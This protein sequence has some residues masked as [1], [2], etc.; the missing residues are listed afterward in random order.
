MM[1]TFILL[2]LISCSKNK[3]YLEMIPSDT[4]F[5]V[6]INP[7]SIAEKADFNT[8]EQYQLANSLIE[9]LNSSDPDLKNLVSEIKESPSSAGIDLLSPIYIFGKKINGKIITSLIMNMNNKT[10]FEDHLKTIYKAIYK[11]NIS[12]IDENG[13]T[14][15]EGSRKPFIAW[16]KKQFIFIAG[17]FGTKSTTLNTY[18][19]SLIKAENPLIKNLNFAEFVKRSEDINLWYN[20]TFFNYIFKENKDNIDLSNCSWT[21]YISFND[22]NISFIQ[23]FHPD[24][25]AKIFFTKHPLWKRRINTDFYKYVPAKSYLNFSFALYP[26]NINTIFNENRTITNQLNDYNI[27]L[28]TLK[29]S[30]EGDAIF[31]IFELDKTQSFNVNN[32]FKHDNSFKSYDIIPQFVFISKMKNDQFIKEI[33]NTFGKNIK[34]QGEYYTVAIGSNKNLYIAYKNNLAYITNNYA[35]VNKFITNKIEKNN[36][37][38]SEYAGEAKN[39]MFFNANLNLDDYSEDTKNYIY[40]QI[41]LGKTPLVQ[42]FLNQFSKA[43]FTIADDF[44]KKGSITLK[45]QKGNSLKTILT[46]LDQAYVL[47]TNPQME[48]YE[49]N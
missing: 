18:F 44:T 5:V 20:G 47:Y 25:Q 42:T 6:Q 17:E 35:Q 24:P 33:V 2:Q 10:D 29:S 49:S 45:N 28:E 8:I 26:Q 4:D 43:N 3:D 11:K 30:A 7:K 15:I 37:L 40:S 19:E 16:N 32:Y 14:Y 1:I 31:S 34:K 36:F 12:F 39:A 27:N 23:D 41:P 48:S 38:K 13:Y 9:T 21:N 46:F 22:N